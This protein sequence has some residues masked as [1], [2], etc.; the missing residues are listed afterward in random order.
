LAELLAFSG[1]DN[2]AMGS[3]VRA[4]DSVES[5]SKWGMAN[6]VDGYTSLVSLSAL[7]L[8]KE[9]PTDGYRSKVAAVSAIEKWVQVDLGRPVPIREVRLLPAQPKEGPDVAGF[10]FPL[11]LKIE[12]S[13]DPKF[14][15]CKTL[16]DQTSSDVPNPGDSALTIAGEFG[17]ARYVRVT[18]T[19]LRKSLDGYQMALAELQVFSG[20]ENVAAGATGTALD[21]EDFERWNKAALVDSYTSR[22][23]IVEVVS[24]I[25]YSG[26]R[27]ALELELKAVKAER[28]QLLQSLLEPAFRA[29]LKEID[30]QLEAI[31]HR[32]ATLPPPQMLYAAASDFPPVSSFHS[33]KGV[34]RP[35]HVLGRGEVTAP[36]ELV[37]PGAL[38]FGEGEYAEIERVIQK[39]LK[40]NGAAGLDDSTVTLSAPG[41]EA[42]PSG[43]VKSPETYVGYR[44]A[45][46]FSSPERLGRD[47]RKTYSPPA[48]LSLNQWG[49]AGS[50]NVGAKSAVLQA[51]TGRIVFRFHSRDLHLVLATA[52]DA[53]PVRF[54]VRLDG[55]VPGEHCGVDTAPDGSGEIR[56]PRL[57]QLIR[58]K[59]PIVDRTFEIEFLDPGVHALDFTFG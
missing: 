15:I 12:T 46:R 8:S 10:G 39:L 50:W 26:R 47:S 23:G 55:A 25:K 27:H 31:N 9:S 30:Q 20:E 44:L 13:N 18:A 2:V 36:G 51:A 37:A 48:S 22:T 5:R 17:P 19:R 52:K 35:I 49:L 43:D 3:K 59:V 42:V 1:E 16:S 7:G 56:E 4:A 53:K 14:E 45:E 38:H 34:P 40:Q 6:L 28:D 58:Q 54:V 41:V 21:S 57:Y 32:L 29:E 33:T 24:A 11:R